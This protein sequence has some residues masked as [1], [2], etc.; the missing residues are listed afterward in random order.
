MEVTF[1]THRWQFFGWALFHLILGGVLIYG[2][3]TIGKG[4]GVALLAFGAIRLW[5]F[6][7]TLLKPAGRVRVGSD[8]LELPRALCVSKADSVA[9][10]AIQNVYFL[11]RSL[12]WT[13][14]SPVLIIETADRTYDYPRDWFATDSEQRR[15]AD[16]LA[17]QSGRA[18]DPSLV[19]ERTEEV[20]DD[21][22]DPRARVRQAI[23]CFAGAIGLVVL[24]NLGFTLE[25][26]RVI[27]VPPEWLYVIAAV[28]VVIGV[29]LLAR[30][31]T[32][33]SA[34]AEPE[35]KSPR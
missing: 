16:A 13:Q 19:P 24:K 21:A 2:L 22:P 17:R 9:L 7:R 8:P 6:V 25:I 3:G 30:P 12:P 14:A 27:A 1:E 10:D 31:G 34:E 15:I 18:L 20:E 5:R 35:N 23:A 29:W 11:R 32:D 4:V 26:K 28:L 33:G